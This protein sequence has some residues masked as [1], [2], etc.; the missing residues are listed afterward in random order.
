MK[1]HK[2]NFHKNTF[3]VFQK[4]SEDTIPD[5]VHFSSKY[6]SKYIFTDKGVYRCSNHWG[7]VGNCR[8]RLAEVDYKQQTF[9]W[10]FAHWSDFFSNKEDQPIYFI[11][12]IDENIFSI[13]HK[14]A[15]T[16]D[17]KP[18]LRTAKEAAKIIQKLKE[19]TSS[20]QWAKYLP[21]E[22]Y[23]EMKCFFIK[24]LLTTPQNFLQIQKEYLKK[25]TK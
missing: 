20:T 22:N 3:A 21:Y 2:N 10:G 15:I 6:G 23:E 24:N 16:S 17:G 14:D 11:E 1:F 5:M 13:N 12:Q 8:W 4:V 18:P 25:I 9:F 7:R 19:I